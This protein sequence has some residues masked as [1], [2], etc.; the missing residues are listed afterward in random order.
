MVF[1]H[2]GSLLPA[3]LKGKGDAIIVG[4]SNTSDDG[5]S[6]LASKKPTFIKS[7]SNEKATI[8]HFQI[9]F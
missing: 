6:F 1:F 7:I 4:T 5:P 8:P 2:Q 3:T 9:F